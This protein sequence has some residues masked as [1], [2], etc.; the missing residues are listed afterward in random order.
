MVFYGLS[1]RTTHPDVDTRINARLHEGCPPMI[2][3][4][5]QLG[6]FVNARRTCHSAWQSS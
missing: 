2:S 5:A 6:R 3:Q 4:A 1:G